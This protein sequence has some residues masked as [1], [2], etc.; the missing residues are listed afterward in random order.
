MDIGTINDS[1]VRIAMH[2]RILRC[3]MGDNPT[4]CPLYKV[5]LLPMMERLEWLNSKSDLE[6]TALLS[7]HVKCFRKKVA[8]AA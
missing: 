3:P 7:Y 6:L 4:D 1:E 8:A 2:G 5:R